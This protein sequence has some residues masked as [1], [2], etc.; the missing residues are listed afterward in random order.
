VILRAIAALIVVASDSR[1]VVPPERLPV[2]HVKLGNGLNVILARDTSATSVAV[3]VRYRSGAASERADEA[4]YTHLL[5]LLLGEGSVHVKDFTARIDA[6]GGWATTTATS[7]YLGM[8]EQVPAHA[9]DLVLWLEAE[10]MAGLADG[11]GAAGV[12]HAR[13]LIAAEWRAAYVDD[14]YALVAREVQRGLWTGV[15]DGAAV[16]AEIK[17]ADVEAV[18]RFARERLVPNNATIVIAGRFDVAATRKLVK[19][20][21]GWIPPREL[22]PAT[23]AKIEPRATAVSVTVNDPVPKVVVAF[24]CEPFTPAIDVIGQLLAGGPTARLVIA[25]VDTGLAS[26]VHAEVTRQRA[27]ELRIVTTPAAGVDPARVAQVIQ[28][29]L[30]KLRAQPPS[31]DE[32]GRARMRLVTDFF[33]AMEN[34]AVRAELLASWAEFGSRDPLLM[35][36]PW[37]LDG[38][39]IDLKP[40]IARWLGEQSAVTVI[41]RPEGT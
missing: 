41:A 36:W 16:L 3:H 7:D 39:G 9:L 5:E 25:L 1:A 27:A 13:E 11:I 24:R 29:E 10:R 23:R 31:R 12:A 22:A 21:F 28:A 17:A 14:P 6:A 35:A 18:R 26:E 37:M 34:L 20:Y 38:S 32:L 30:A 19:R 40:V 15:R 2:E 4:G 33:V 8:T